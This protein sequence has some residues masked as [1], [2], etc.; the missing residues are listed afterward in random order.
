MKRICVFLGSSSGAQRGYLEATRDLGRELARRQLTL[1]YGGGNVGLMGELAKTVLKEGGE[2]IGIIPQPLM[3]KEGRQIG[4]S[5]LRVVA[6]MHERKAQMSELADAFI[7]LPGGIGTL[8]EFFE[9]LSWAQLGFHGKPCGV[10][11]VCNYYE[12]L[13]RFLDHVVAEGFL[14]EE[15]RSMLLVGETARELLSELAAYRSP[16]LKRWIN[17]QQI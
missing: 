5:E 8:E 10:L 9:V 4:L 12:G 7:V 3:E 16:A 2:V 17:R 11:N 14:E 6:S 15:H 1:V 13:I